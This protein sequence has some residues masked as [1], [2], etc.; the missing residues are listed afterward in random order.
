ME[1]IEVVG[2]P[3][4]SINFKGEIINFIDPNIFMNS[5][6]N[7]NKADLLLKSTQNLLSI[8]GDFVVYAGEKKKTE[9]LMKQLESK[10]SSLYKGLEEQKK[11][12]EIEVKE[13][14]RRL[15]NQLKEKEELMEL[16]LE[17]LKSEVKSKI[18]N[19]KKQ[20][21]QF[22]KQ[23]NINSRIMD[24]FKDNL[25]EISIFIETAREEFDFNRQDELLERY[26]ELQVEYN[27]LFA[28]N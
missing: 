2:M 3:N 11:R 12:N 26:R 22:L 21:E 20:D 24:I 1:K 23:L 18:K 17:K 6:M 9:E 13:F 5:Q 19:Y 4:R 28:N 14:E 15:K 27:K 10:K 16:E 25:N 7:F 8:I